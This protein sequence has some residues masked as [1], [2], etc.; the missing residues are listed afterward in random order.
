MVSKENEMVDPSEAEV[1]LEI[2]EQAIYTSLRRVDVSTRYSSKQ[3]IVILMDSNEENGNLVAE[4][5]VNC[6]RKL[7]K[8]K[9]ISFEYGIAE[10]DKLGNKFI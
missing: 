6:F 10:M 3:L 2:M 4:R 5:I 1:A 7:Y 9:K 8:G